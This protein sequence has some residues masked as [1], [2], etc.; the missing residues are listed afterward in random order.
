M[1]AMGLVVTSTDYEDVKQ[2]LRHIFTVALYVNE[3]YTTSG[4]PNPCE[5]AKSFL[6]TRIAGHSDETENWETYENSK[7]IND[8]D[9]P[10]EINDEEMDNEE[11]SQEVTGS[12]LQDA[13]SIF[14]QVEKEASDVSNDG[15]RGNVNYSPELA[16]KL[17]KF[18]KLIP[19]WSGIMVPI[20]RY[21]P[22]TEASATVESV[23]N[24]CI[25]TPPPQSGVG[26]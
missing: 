17:V 16:S 2:I 20:F 3:G 15:N 19:C 21:G 26:G 12:F 8:P 18:C 25:S 14:E 11:V 23:F 4:E 22:A 1:Q 6:Q 10:D 5:R 9:D 13:V 24:G 7:N